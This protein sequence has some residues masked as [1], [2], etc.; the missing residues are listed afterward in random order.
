LA[1]QAT[2]R[3]KTGAEITARLAACDAKRVLLALR[4]KGAN[5]NER[6]ATRLALRDLAAKVAAPSAVPA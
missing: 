6:A 3:R 1:E 5:G 4:P 2:S